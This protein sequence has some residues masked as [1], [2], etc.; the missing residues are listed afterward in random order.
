MALFMHSFSVKPDSVLSFSV[1]QPLTA[2]RLRAA[3]DSLISFDPCE[4][5]PLP[6]RAKFFA[7]FE[8]VM[9]EFLKAASNASIALTVGEYPPNTPT[10]IAID[11]A[12]LTAIFPLFKKG[13]S[14]VD[15]DTV[16]WLRARRRFINRRRDK[17]C[18]IS[19]TV[20][21]TVES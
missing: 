19:E 8:Y 1:L 20:K 12:T 15:S 13:L 2:R 3:G 17:A 18:I 4:K 7:L 21:S 14:N 10:P 11:D 9:A 6:I 16:R 5:S